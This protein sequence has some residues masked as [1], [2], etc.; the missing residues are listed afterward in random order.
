[1]RET[2]EQENMTYEEEKRRV[3][4]VF[5][6]AGGFS[7]NIG[8]LGAVLGLI[9]VM[10][11]L[12]DPSKLGGGI[13]VAFVATIYGVA[14]ANLV[15]LPM[16]KKL[17]NRLS[18]ELSLREMLIEGVVGIQSGMN[19]GTSRRNSG[20]SWRPGTGETPRSALRDEKEKQEGPRR[21]RQVD[22]LLRGFH[23]ASVCLLHHDVRDKPSGRRQTGGVRRLHEVRLQLG[24]LRA[25]GFPGGLRGLQPGLSR[26]GGIEE[27]F[28]E[29][30]GTLKEKEDIG[31][32]TEERGV[33]V[34]L[35]DRVLFNVG[36]AGIKEEATPALSTIASVIAGIPNDISIEGH[37]DNVPISNSRYSSNWEL[38]TSRAVSVLEFLVRKRGLSPARFSAA[39]YAEFRPVAPNETR[40][41]VQET[42]GWT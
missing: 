28:R 14:L 37:T 35:G 1:V 21:Y 25:G 6:T 39:G 13:A 34:S 24:A 20:S 18:Y 9:H 19:P 29:V 4:R 22:S 36:E 16:S 31:V 2:I 26:P 33:V 38:S 30:V 15:L 7:P 17:M 41:G 11:N 8:I 40:R 23:H 12:S 32:T 42:A 5:E 10:K 3:A 27:K